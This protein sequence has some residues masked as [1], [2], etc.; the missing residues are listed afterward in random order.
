M[1]IHVEDDLRQPL[2]PVLPNEL[3][4]QSRF[5][6]QIDIFP[7]V[8][9]LLQPGDMVVVLVG[10]IDAVYLPDTA[11]LELRLDVRRCIEQKFIT[12]E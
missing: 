1:D 11:G 5:H 10:D 12:G 3:P 8:E 4:V 6:K 9:E 7:P 2:S